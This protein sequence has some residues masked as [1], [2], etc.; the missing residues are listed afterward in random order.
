MTRGEMEKASFWF[1]GG[2]VDVASNN[3][4]GIE[5]S[6][7]SPLQWL[8]VD[9]LKR[10]CIQSLETGLPTV[11]V[12]VGVSALGVVAVGG[13]GGV[14]EAGCMAVTYSEKSKSISRMLVV[15]KGLSIN[16]ASHNKMFV[17]VCGQKKEVRRCC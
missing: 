6:W 7:V 12:G 1:D 14:G 5:S 4:G 17:L 9:M 2:C 3:D 15:I 11:G 10:A 13:Y 16:I 8:A